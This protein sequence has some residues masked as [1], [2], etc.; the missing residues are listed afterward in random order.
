MYSLD[1]KEIPMRNSA[2]SD[3]RMNRAE[4]DGRSTVS[5]ATPGPAAAMTRQESSPP[6]RR[7]KDGTS[8]ADAAG[9]RHYWLAPLD[10]DSVR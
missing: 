1:G 3:E 2:K 10:R 5:V 9:A 7:P 4:G 6:N 8:K